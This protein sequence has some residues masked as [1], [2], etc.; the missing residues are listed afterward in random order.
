VTKATKQSGKPQQMLTPWEKATGVGEAAMPGVLPPRFSGRLT[1]A[2]AMLLALLFW[3]LFGLSGVFMA[4]VFARLIVLDLATYTLPNIY[5]VPL[6]LVGLMHAADA[7]R[8]LPVF[9]FWL[10]LAL[11]AGL[12]RYLLRS[13]GLG[14]GDLKLLAAL[15]AFLGALPSLTAVAVGCLLWLPVVWGK[16][17]QAVPLGVPLLVGWAIV[18][19]FPHLPNA[20]FSPISY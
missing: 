6:M 20:L 13:F 16:P 7:D 4:F 17:K 2:F 19:A 8:A 12:G 9:I 15:V 11:L 18:L 3:P 10:A 14:E 5:T 1:L